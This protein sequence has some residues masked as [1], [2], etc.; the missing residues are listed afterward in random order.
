LSDRIDRS[1]SLLAPRLSGER[2][3]GSLAGDVHSQHLTCHDPRSGYACTR[4]MQS[5]P[6]GMGH[7]GRAALSTLEGLA[8]A[9]SAGDIGAD[10]I[11]S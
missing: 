8:A 7:A 1:P 2:E 10:S 11:K 9:S 5:E 6:F 4:S 3:V